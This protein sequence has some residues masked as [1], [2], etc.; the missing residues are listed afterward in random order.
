MSGIC[1]GRIVVVTGA[2]RGIGRE[3]ALEFARQGARVVVND[4]GGEVDGTGA[5]ATPAAGVAEE[6]EALGGEAVVNGDDVS[7][8]AGAER[9]IQTAVDRFGG[10]DVLV[11]NAGILRDRM[12]VKMSEEDFDSVVDTSMRSRRMPALFTTAWRPPNSSAAWAIM[13]CT[14]AASV[15]ESPL[16]TARPPAA[17][18]SSTTSWAG[19]VCRP[20]PSWAPPRSFTTTAAPS[21]AMVSA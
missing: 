8:W 19:P 5:S 9:L 1:E 10:L 7:D 13:R 17:T 3:H 11:N 2:G 6:I 15:T 20:L 21:A 14:P 12:L 18:I 16:A 4:L